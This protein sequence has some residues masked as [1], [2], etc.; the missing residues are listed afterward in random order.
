MNLY[1]ELLPYWRAHA[2]ARRR[3]A[4]AYYVAWIDACVRICGQGVS[5]E[6]DDEGCTV[7]GVMRFDYESVR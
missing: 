5:I 7:A 6:W 1:D 4:P 2:E 3:R